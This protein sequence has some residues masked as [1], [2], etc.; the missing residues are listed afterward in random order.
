LADRRGQSVQAVTIS[1]LGEDQGL[2]AQGHLFCVG[3]LPRRGE[4]GGSLDPLTA[5]RVFLIE[6]HLLDP[7]SKCL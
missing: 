2:M 4:E 7:P 6:S 5:S 3:L 1:G